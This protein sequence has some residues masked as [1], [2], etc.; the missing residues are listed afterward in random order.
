[1]DG[2]MIALATIIM[3][4]CHPG[5]LLGPKSSWSEEAIYRREKDQLN[6]YDRQGRPYDAYEAVRL[7]GSAE[8][9]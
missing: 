6:G 1:M 2:V 4:V 8:R 9:V 5:R 3:N 7:N